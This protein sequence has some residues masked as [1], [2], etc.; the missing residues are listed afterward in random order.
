[1]QSTKTKSSNDI[2][3]IFSEPIEFL[4]PLSSVWWAQIINTEFDIISYW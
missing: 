2:K 3:K 1:M 4:I